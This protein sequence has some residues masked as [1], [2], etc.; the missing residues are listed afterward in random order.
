MVSVTG[1]VRPSTI[2][3]ALTCLRRPGAVALGGGT[4]LN[5]TP[6]AGPAVLVDLQA[7]GLDRVERHGGDRLVVGAGVTLQALV[8]DP[9]VPPVLRDAA[10]RELPSTLRAA[11]TVGGCVAT[12]DWESELFATLLVHDAL[13]HT[14]AGSVVPLGGPLALA[15][16]FVTAIELDTGGACASARTGR[17]RADRPI[18]AAVARRPPGGPCRLALSGIASR[19]QLVDDVDELD[20]P[21]DFRGSS[22]YRRAL[23]ATLAQRALEE[24]T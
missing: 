11:A 23:A 8:D 6:G 17:T 18:V 1:Y 15:G 19:P 9:A 10:R 13:V 24:V 5:A 12:A 21:S 14:A 7:L 16:D 2:E 4:R 20:P 22:G 3:E